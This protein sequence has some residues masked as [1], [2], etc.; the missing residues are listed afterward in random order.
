MSDDYDPASEGA[1]MSFDDRMSYADYLNLDKLLS[2]Q[3]PISTAHDEFLFICL[4]YT[5]PS[6]RDS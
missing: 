5:S 4:L 2:A 6:P 1:Q 3:H